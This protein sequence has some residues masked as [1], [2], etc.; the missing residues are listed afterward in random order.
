MPQYTGNL[1]GNVKHHIVTQ[2]MP[3][4]ERAHR[5][6]PHKF[7]AAKQQ[8]KQILDH[9]ICRPFS[10][11][12][13]SPIHMTKKAN[14]G[15][16]RYLNAVTISDKYPVPHILYMISRLTYVEKQYFPNST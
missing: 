11:P 9:G 8:F 2:G 4:A 6:A 14:S 13:A 16:F 5:L 10:S 7:V 3:L 12:Q 15:D 1:M